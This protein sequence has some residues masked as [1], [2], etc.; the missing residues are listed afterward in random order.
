MRV[1]QP[2]SDRQ[3][4]V[5]DFK[6]GDRVA[7]KNRTTSSIFNRRASIADKTATVTRVRVDG[8]GR[9]EKVFITTDNG[10][11]THRLPKN[12]SKLE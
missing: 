12:L 3:K 9:I 8:N 4:G 11:A 7:I 6:Q 5:L 10:L 1:S 2:A